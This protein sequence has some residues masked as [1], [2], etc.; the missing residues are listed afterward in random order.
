MQNIRI[1][2]KSLK[3][4]ELL[5]KRLLHGDAFPKNTTSE[6]VN[7][8]YILRNGD[9]VKVQGKVGDNVMKLSHRYFFNSFSSFYC[10]HFVIL[11][12]LSKFLKFLF[13]HICCLFQTVLFIFSIKMAA[14][15]FRFLIQCFYEIKKPR[16]KSFY[17]T[18]IN[19]LYQPI[20]FNN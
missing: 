14:K 17:L 15:L 7:V 10:L 16:R 11:C 9:E 3:M 6:R 8:T 1:L 20:V 12:L 2:T 13:C 5:S 19:P 4:N 18:K